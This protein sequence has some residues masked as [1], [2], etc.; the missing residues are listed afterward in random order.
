MEDPRTPPMV[1]V[2]PAVYPAYPQNLPAPVIDIVEDLYL[3]D[4]YQKNQQG[5]K[6]LLLQETSI[7]ARPSPWKRQES[8]KRIH[9]TM[10]PL[11]VDSLIF[12]L[13]GTLWDC[14]PTGVQAWTETFRDCGLGALPLSEDF[15][16]SFVGLPI[17]TVF[18][19]LYPQGNEEKYRMFARQLALNEERLLKKRLNPL[20]PGVNRVL[21][22]L[23]A[24][25]PLFVV[26]NCL[27]GYIEHFLD[28]YGLGSVV[29][30]FE[31]YGD[32]GRPKKDNIQAVD[33]RHGMTRPVYIGDTLTDCQAAR[34]NDMPFIWARYGYGQVKEAAY[35]IDQFTELPTL[36]QKTGEGPALLAQASNF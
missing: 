13:D 18:Q 10:K 8:V 29:T 1:M 24:H 6:L 33:Q 12:D 2:L 20:Y 14:I 23:A 7:P 21:R 27:S 22:E 17:N 32:T 4:E 11:S 15:V 19:L 31:C 9:I 34:E 26:S 5:P 28:Q 30:D 16:R 3:F 35:F 36:I 25:F